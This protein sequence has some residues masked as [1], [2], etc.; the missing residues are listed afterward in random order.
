MLAFPL[1]MAA[2]CGKEAP[3]PRV[4]R[5]ARTT[6]HG[7][8][9]GRYSLLLCSGRIMNGFAPLAPASSWSRFV[10]P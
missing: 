8:R 5:A 4:E 2:G 3:G 7:R 6:G 1:A 10:H 9:H